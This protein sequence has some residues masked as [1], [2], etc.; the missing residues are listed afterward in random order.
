VTSFRPGDEVFGVA[1][2]SCA[3][4]VRA[5]EDKLAIK[6]VNLTYDEAAALPVSALA[7]L[8]GLRDAG[9]LQP[10]QRVLINGASGGVDTFAVQIAKA[11]GAEVTG[12]T[13]TSNVEMVRNHDPPLPRCLGRQPARSARRRLSS[14]SRS[15]RPRRRQ[16]WRPTRRQARQP[17]PRRG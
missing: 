14:R 5:S 16:P 13:S 7:A 9:K 3:E 1:N 10:G 2:G 15:L 17:Q 6:P 12:V 8:H 4:Y 11:L